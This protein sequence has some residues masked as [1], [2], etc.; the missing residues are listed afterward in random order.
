MG[1]ASLRAGFCFSALY[2]H[3]QTTPPALQLTQKCANYCHRKFF[4]MSERFLSHKRHFHSSVILEDREQA[5]HHKT[6]ESLKERALLDKTGNSAVEQRPTS[7]LTTTE[8]VRPPKPVIEKTESSLP[9]HDP[10]RITEEQRRLE[11]KADSL[12]QELI[13]SRGANKE[14]FMFAV[15]K[16]VDREGI[17]WRGAVEFIYAGMKEMEN[18]GVLKDLDSYKALIQAFPEK[19]MIPRNAWQVE[20]MHYPRHQQCGIDM[21]EQ[22]EH[23]G[24]IPDE[25]FG[26]L[27]KNRFGGEAHVTRKYR[28]MLYWLPKFKNINPYPIPMELPT[29]PRQLALL[30]LRRMSVDRESQYNVFEAEPEEDTFIASAQSPTQQHLIQQHNT[31]QPLFVEGPYPV[32]LRELRQNYFLLRAEP[33]INALMKKKQQEK[34]EENDENLFEWTNFFEDEKSSEL[35]PIL[36]VHEQD[37]STILALSITG[38]NSKASAMSWVRCLERNNPKLAR[39]PILFKIQTSAE[40]GQVDWGQQAVLGAPT[41]GK[42]F[43]QVALF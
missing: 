38:T 26:A 37:D 16:F 29:D 10:G 43:R 18:F 28:R 2:R 39:I 36:S 22:M 3:I 40:A 24:V 30:A 5:R 21:L 7:D 19:K 33:N 8:Q 11:R 1:K 41:N 4:L 20:F 23:N 6:D 12:F 25:A 35:R 27:L 13:E 9:N 15:K 34:A 31:E 42:D 17:Y 14:T 32:Y